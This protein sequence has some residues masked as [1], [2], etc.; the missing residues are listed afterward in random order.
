MLGDQRT[1]FGVASS[2]LLLVVSVLPRCYN[3][4]P[5][6]H[7]TLVCSEQ[8]LRTT[9]LRGV[10]SIR[11]VIVVVC[12]S[13]VSRRVGESL[14]VA[15]R[16]RQRGAEAKGCWNRLVRGLY[17]DHVVRTIRRE[18]TE[19]SFPPFHYGETGGTTTVHLFP[20][21]S[22]LFKPLNLDG[23]VGRR[24]REREREEVSSSTRQSPLGK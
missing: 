21:F 7:A 8:C 22:Y 18:S 2:S 5:I 19:N 10:S 16:V 13:V 14:L 9:T 24:E 4:R 17:S 23:R 3:H 1:I 6:C 20:I 15:F 11:V 12:V